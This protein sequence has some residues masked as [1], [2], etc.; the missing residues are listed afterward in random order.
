M[1]NSKVLAWYKP[2]DTVY[3]I[4]LFKFINPDKFMRLYGFLYELTPFQIEDEASWVQNT[5]L[6]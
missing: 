3:L 4:S 6:H 1:L 5:E 2:T